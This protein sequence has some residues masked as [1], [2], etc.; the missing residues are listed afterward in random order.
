[1][2]HFLLAFFLSLFT[3]AAHAD[4]KQPMRLPVD[5]APLVFETGKGKFSFAVE[6]AR[7]EN[8]RERG[9]MWRR[10]FP[11]S[12]AML[13]VF[14]E[15]RRV[16]MWMENTPLPLDMV[17]LDAKGRVSAVRVDAVPFSQDIISSGPPAAY[18]VEL[19]AGTARRDGIRP[20]D[21]A[22]HPAICGKC[23]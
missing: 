11:A 5:K 7:S 4:E 3:V 2:R 20:G 6:I 8:E 21:R 12:R 14:G 10:D 13:F 18:V 15:T 17:F 22:I 1:M 9:L 23:R 16:M 19:V